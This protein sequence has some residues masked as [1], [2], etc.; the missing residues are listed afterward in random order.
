MTII[1]KQLVSALTKQSA[2]LSK[3]IP[4]QLRMASF[5]ACHAY[6]SQSLS[7]FTSGRRRF[8]CAAAPKRDA[9]SSENGGSSS[10]QATNDASSSGDGEEVVKPD[11]NVTGAEGVE[12]VF[13]YGKN[14]AFNK[15]LYTAEDLERTGRGVDEK[16]TECMSD[17]PEKMANRP[18]P[19]E[20]WEG[21]CSQ[22]GRL[23]S[24]K[25]IL[26]KGEIEKLQ[27]ASSYPAEHKVVDMT[28]ETGE[29][30]RMKRIEFQKLRPMTDDELWTVKHHNE[31]VTATD[32]VHLSFH[33]SFDEF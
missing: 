29:T 27:N 32:E 10:S 2:G 26:S 25:K 19:W 9:Q 3:S 30:I 7:Y 5:A 4:H 16:L 22:D 1:A 31:L 13:G 14:G 21:F 23:D 8:F 15:I 12:S 33:F 6:Q 17:I 20:T 24:D 28:M 18:Q 11:G